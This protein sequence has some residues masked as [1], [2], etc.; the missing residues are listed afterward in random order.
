MWNFS[1]LSKVN[2]SGQ[3]LLVTDI[4][5]K[6]LIPL[7]VGGLRSLCGVTDIV[8]VAPSHERDEFRGVVDSYPDVHVLRDPD[9]LNFT[10]KDISLHQIPSFPQ[11]AGWFFQQFL[12]LG[13]ASHPMARENYLVWDADTIPLKPMEFCRDGKILFTRGLEYF[14][15][16]FDTIEDLFGFKSAF[17]CSVISQHSLLEKA[18]INEM[19]AFVK[20]KRSIPSFYECVLK[21]CVKRRSAFF[22][23]YETYAAFLARHRPHKYLCVRRRWFR[24][25]A[26]LSAVPPSRFWLSFLAKFFDFATFEAWDI[27]PKRAVKS[28]AKLIWAVAI[29]TSNGLYR[30]S[31]P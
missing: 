13:F 12:K 17:A 29:P 9:V 25:A 16:Y 20:R 1:P 10:V 2:F 15:E 7:V 31:R 26:A 11:R 18:L 24:N 27:G 3:A 30:T 23:E 4:R 22:S 8:I 19:F 5:N 21:S 14:G 6:E 28:L